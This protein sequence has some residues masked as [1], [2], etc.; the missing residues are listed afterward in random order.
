MWTALA[1][2]PREVDGS[3]IASFCKRRAV[4]GPPREGEKPRP[5]TSAST[6]RAASAR[7]VTRGARV[8]LQGSQLVQEDARLRAPTASAI[9]ALSA[10]MDVR[11]WTSMHRTS[12]LGNNRLSTSPFASMAFSHR[13]RYSTDSDEREKYPRVC[14]RA[15]RTRFRRVMFSRTSGSSTRR[16]SI[17]I[18]SESGYSKAERI[19]LTCPSSTI[20]S[21]YVL[22]FSRRAFRCMKTCRSL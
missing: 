16:S 12:R 18:L 1:P 4:N 20:S 2:T 11:S 8:R 22:A 7:V 14:R 5:V 17:S 15:L 6:S 13:T 9:S 21:R 3:R 19:L 10:S